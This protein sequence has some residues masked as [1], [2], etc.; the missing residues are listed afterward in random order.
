MRYSKSEEYAKKLQTTEWMVF[1]KM[2][3][4]RDGYRCTYDC[5]WTKDREIPLVAHHKVYYMIDGEFVEPWDYSLDDMITLC[6]TCHDTYHIGFGYS[7]PIIDKNIN[8]VLNE[9]EPTRRTRLAIE[10]MKNTFDW[11]NENELCRNGKPLKECN[12]C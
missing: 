6:Q 10:K 3:Y 4:A 2:V 8:K 12:C 7:M 9:D 5:G 1:R 11:N